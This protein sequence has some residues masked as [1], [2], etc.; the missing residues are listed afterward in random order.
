MIELRNITKSYPVE[1]GRHY[2]FKDLSLILPSRTNI[3]V[4]GPNGS[5][6]STFLRLISG[7]ELADSGTIITQSEV[8]WPFGLTSGFKGSLTGRQNVSFVCGINGLNKVQTREVIQ[9]VTDFAEIGE[10]FEMPINTYSSGMRA[11][12]S[13]GLSMAFDFDV[14]LVDELT[15]VGDTIFREKAQAAFEKIRERASLIFV[16]HNLNTLRESCES[17]VFLR[18]GL[19][20]FYE[21]I[22]DGINAYADYTNEKREPR[23]AKNL[24]EQREAK[25]LGEIIAARKSKTQDT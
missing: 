23:K 7:A 20:D 12:L 9:Y 19:A 11:R 25:Q 6:K 22:E 1:K 3:A 5:G 14:F 4:F 21:D 13:F 18:D 10:Y 16:A 24:K 8:S 2:I 15:S 17:A